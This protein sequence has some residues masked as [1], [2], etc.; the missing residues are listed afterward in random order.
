M[1]TH[2]QGTRER[3]DHRKKSCFSVVAVNSIQKRSWRVCMYHSQHSRSRISGRKKERKNKV[4]NI[5]L[6]PFARHSLCWHAWNYGAE[7]V[8]MATYMLS[9]LLSSHR[10]TESIKFRGRTRKTFT[11]FFSCV[12]HN[13]LQLYTWKCIYM[14]KPCFW[15]R[16]RSNP[17]TI[18]F[19]SMILTKHLGEN[20]RHVLPAYFLWRRRKNKFN[21]VVVATLQF[22]WW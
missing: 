6:F 12:P 9:L 18:F 19:P 15:R 21:A 5:V 10:R 20:N 22:F 14:R 13:I 3:D 7:K 11:H 17:N 2:E 4:P 8:H 16:C 1:H